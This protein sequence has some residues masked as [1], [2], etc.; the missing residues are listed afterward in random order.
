VDIF[1][2]PT[3]ATAVWAKQAGEG[4]IYVENGTNKGFVPVEGV[5]VKGKICTV[6]FAGESVSIPPQTLEEGDLVARPTDPERTGYDFKGW[7]TDNNTFANEWDFDN[8]FVTGDMALY[9][10]WELQDGIENYAGSAV[11]VYPNPTTGK[12][13]ITNYELRIEGIEIFD[14]YGR[15]ISSHHLIT[16]SSNQIDISHLPEGVYFVK[17]QTEAGEVV[18]KVVKE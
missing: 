12:L 18:K 3:S 7:F 16:T 4:G 9:A 6:T 8:D 14:I 13:R 1:K 11:H 15:K 10:K 17:I 2:D 5:T